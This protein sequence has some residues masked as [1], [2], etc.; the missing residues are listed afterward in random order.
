MVDL[1]DHP[2]P[3]FPADQVDRVTAEAG[4]AL[5][6]WE[7]GPATTVITGGARG[8]DLIV[9]EQALAR[10]A[11]VMVCLALPADEFEQRS[12]LVPGT[13]W[14]TRF[15]KVI[16]ASE[17]RAAPTGGGDPFE[18]A[19][20]AMVELARQID[21]DPYTLLVWNGRASRGAGG[22]ADLIKRL[23]LDRP[24]E[25]VAVIDPTRRRYQARQSADGPKR[26]LALDGGGIRG[27]VS[28]EIL[29]AIES[30]LRARYRREDLVLADFF[31]YVAG[32]STGAVIASAL[33]LGSPVAE[34]RERYASLGRQV[35]KRQR[36]TRWGRA[37]YTDR[38]LR[39]Q[40]EDMLGADRTLGSPEARS[41][42]LLVMHNLVTD[43]PWSLSNCTRA[44]YNNADRNLLPAPDRN[45]DIPLTQLVRASAAA[46]VYFP[47]ET[48][49]IG[50][51]KFV[52]QDGGITPHNNPAMLV[53]LMATLPEYGLAWR[54]GVNNMLLVSVGTGSWAAVHPAL[55]STKVNVGFHARNLPAVFMNGASVAHDLTCR[56]LG[57]CVTGPAID[58]EVGDRVGAASIGGEGMFTYAR[59]DADLSDQALIEAGYHD[60]RVRRR[61]RKLDAVDCLPLLQQLG[62][63]V[64][65]H[66]DIEDQLRAF[67]GPL[68]G[69][70]NDGD[71]PE[72]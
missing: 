63:R 12:V 31:D 30:Q 7:V 49:A 44:K 11:R 64:A 23:K 39:Q 19:N 50:R 40:L 24:A 22:T 1:I 72:H 66:V 17:V 2:A 46:P 6:R 35:F 60:L 38:G 48:L 13:D 3:R 5:D 65:A 43:S 67:L 8:A 55:R 10:G 56:S 29:A 71:S 28:I 32:T 53:F 9:A 33:A 57:R 52:F 45:L 4:E 14:V 62:R 54:T 68:P 15:R 26:L 58:R 59:Y 20:S 37:I 41:L 21:P 47:P 51:R 36:P 18:N 70:G 25:R 42:L 69:Y 34:L 16:A 27:A 61:L